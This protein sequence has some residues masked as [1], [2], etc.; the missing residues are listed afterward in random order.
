[1][2]LPP[3]PARAGRPQKRRLTAFT[4]YGVIPLLILTLGVR[5]GMFLA[6]Q[7]VPNPDA[8][9]AMTRVAADATLAETPAAAAAPSRFSCEAALS[10]GGNIY[11][12][13]L[14]SFGAAYPEYARNLTLH[15]RNATAGKAVQIR[16]DSNLFLQPFQQS[17]SA[18]S[19]DFTLSPDL[20]WNYAALRQLSQSRP[21][22]FV[23]TTSAEGFS[24]E[25][26]TLVCNVHSINE[27]VARL[28][29]AETGQWQ[30][31]SICFAAFVNEDH[32]WIAS[33]LQEAM[34]RGGLRAITGYESGPYTVTQQ[35][36]AV[37][38]AL[39]ARG[40]TYVNVATDSSSSSGVDTQFVR[41]LDQSVQ[42]QGAN[43]VDASVLFA[44]IFRRM[45]L[46]PVLFFRPG[47][48]FVGYYDAAEGGHMIALETTYL[49]SGSFASAV[50]AGTQELQTTLPYLGTSQYAAVDIVQARRLGINPIGYSGARP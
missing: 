32:P 9:Q 45:G 39:A 41:F 5:I 30:D 28:Y 4:R 6:R 29:N 20:P 17:A 35:A 12:S 8:P 22:S 36:Q 26:Q 50:I 13:L 44:S 34:A 19:A 15:I 31:T 23:V 11:P 24:T 1:M 3:S 40:L 42:D 46:R 2:P 27:V 33:L 21:E 48:C 38:E 10:F 47:H 7:P 16:I 14:L 18:P 43:C 37:W 49:N 25:Q